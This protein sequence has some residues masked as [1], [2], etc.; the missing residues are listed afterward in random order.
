MEIFNL[1]RGHFALLK[2]KPMATPAKGNPFHI[3]DVSQKVKW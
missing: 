3:E 2:D 1:V